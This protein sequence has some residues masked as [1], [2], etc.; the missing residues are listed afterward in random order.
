MPSSSS[1]IGVIS[2]WLAGKHSKRKYQRRH[3]G[4]RKWRI[5]RRRKKKIAENI[6]WRS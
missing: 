3:N 4:S 1:G 6:S 5:N 2:A